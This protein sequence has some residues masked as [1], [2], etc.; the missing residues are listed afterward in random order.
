[1]S[2]RFPVWFRVLRWGCVLG[3]V[4]SVGIWIA[5]LP[6]Y[7]FATPGRNHSIRVETGRI[8]YEYEPRR[9][10][11]DNGIA[12]NTE[13]MRW[14]LDFHFYPD[15]SWFVRLPLWIPTLVFSSAA[16]GTFVLPRVWRCPGHCRRRYA[17]AGL[18]AVRG[19]VTCPEC[20]R[21][22]EVPL[23]ARP[24]RGDPR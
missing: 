16:V 21:T 10:N 18:A 9:V 24:P 13:P 7:Y 8:N 14:G 19:A 5:T 12:H 20:G 11:E 4:V 3:A 1:M 17:L 6:L 22:S 2:R 15:G 23:W